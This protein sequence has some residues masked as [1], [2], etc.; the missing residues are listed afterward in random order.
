MHWV[1]Y[2]WHKIPSKDSTEFA[3]DADSNRINKS[4]GEY[5]EWKIQGVDFKN[6]DILLAPSV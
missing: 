5:Q 4:L 2:I 6:N 3:H 1:Y